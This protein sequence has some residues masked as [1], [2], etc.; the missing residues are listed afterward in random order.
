MDQSAF[1]QLLSTPRPDASSQGLSSSAPRHFGKTQ[2]RSSKESVSD[3]KKSSRIFFDAVQGP[4]PSS[5][6][7]E[8]SSKASDLLPRK[9]GSSHKRSGNDSNDKAK[10][11]AVNSTT[12]ESYVDRAEAR[13]LGKEEVN[14]YK[15][16]ETLRDDFERRIRE[17]ENEDEKEKV[18]AGSRVEVVFCDRR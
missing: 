5:L 14:E 3:Q 10:T 8:Q 9:V 17:A 13:R 16:A 2:K 6:C 7:F 15:D 18:G 12:G 1:R 4:E 11:P